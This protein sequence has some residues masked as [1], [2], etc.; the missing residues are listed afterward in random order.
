M[1]ATSSSPSLAAGNRLLVNVLAKLETVLARPPSDETAALISKLASF[2]CYK[3]TEFSTGDQ[4]RFAALAPRIMVHLTASPQSLFAMENLL[5]NLIVEGPCGIPPVKVAASNGS[6]AADETYVV[7]PCIANL[8]ALRLAAHLVLCNHNGLY[9]LEWLDL[10]YWL[11]ANHPPSCRDLVTA[12]VLLALRPM[13]PKG[14]SKSSRDLGPIRT[15]LVVRIMSSITSHFGTVHPS[16]SDSDD[17]EDD[18]DSHPRPVFHPEYT[19]MLRQNRLAVWNSGM[20]SLLIDWLTRDQVD[21]DRLLEPVARVL[22]RDVE[23]WDKANAIE[24]TNSD[25]YDQ[26]DVHLMGAKILWDVARVVENGMF[27]SHLR[28]FFNSKSAGRVHDLMRIPMSS[29]YDWDSDNFMYTLDRIRMCVANH[30]FHAKEL[31]VP[32]PKWVYERRNALIKYGYFADEEGN[33]H[34]PPPVRTT[35]AGGLST[36]TPAPLLSEK[37]RALHE[38]REARIREEQERLAAKARGGKQQQQ[39]K[40]NDVPAS[41]SAPPI[42]A[43]MDIE[44][45]ADAE[46]TA[47]YA[48]FMAFASEAR[49]RDVQELRAAVRLN[50]PNDSQREFKNHMRAAMHRKF[51]GM[52]REEQTLPDPEAHLPPDDLMRPPPAL[53]MPDTSPFTVVAP[54]EHI[55]TVGQPMHLDQFQNLSLRNFHA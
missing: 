19:E 24:P 52:G 6:S 7:S 16:D 50:H 29:L 43:P 14:I 34:E 32:Q 20:C 45:A 13:L 17:D 54:R 47:E 55:P 35:F 8:L 51:G 36:V 37:E 2:D 44:E 48:E 4:R 46:Y 3:G 33:Y 39:Q 22:V 42:S 18:E 15:R 11:A 53:S 27:D 25:E 49:R 41:A 9:S 23:T 26:M 28:H 31:N 40:R 38:R 12:G 10:V 30:L 5:C 21:P 1:S